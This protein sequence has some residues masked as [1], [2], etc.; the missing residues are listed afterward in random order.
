M[1]VGGARGSGAA[2]AVVAGRVV[3]LA[4]EGTEMAAADDESTEHRTA[5]AQ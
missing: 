5:R 2:Q 1:A 4:V 3:A